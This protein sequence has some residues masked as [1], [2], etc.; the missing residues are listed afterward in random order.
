MRDKNLI[1]SVALFSELYN[2]NTY[3]NIP[4]IIAEFIRGAIIFENKYSFNSTE[5][6]DL[7][8]KIYGFDIPESVIRTTLQNKFKDEL[9]RENNYYHFNQN[10]KNSSLN[11]HSDFQEISNS[12]N[13]VI[14]D[15]YAFIEARKKKQL[16]P[17]EKR[18]VLENV[19]QFL[20]DNGYS[21]KYSDLISAYVLIKEKDTKFRELLNSIKEGL[22]LYQGI[23]YTADL[24]QL[25]SW[26]NDLTIYLGTEHLFN[27]LGYN[28]I[29]YKEIFD[30]FYKLVFE[31]NSSQKN[32]NAKRKKIELKYLEETKI[33]IDNFFQTAES[34]KKGNKALDPSKLA[35]ETILKK[36]SS[37]SD[38]KTLRVQFDIELKKLGIQFH[39]FNYSFDRTIQYN[40]VDQK[41]IDEL[42]KLSEEKGRYFSEE[43]CLYY[44]KLFTKINT[45]RNGANNNRFEKCGHLYVTETAFVKYLAHNN[46]VK[47]EDY[48]TPFAKD[49]DFVTTRFWFTL[50]KG[51]S[52]KQSLPKSFDV[53]TKAKIILSSHL[54]NGIS[55]SYE[56]LLAER[57][58]GKLTDE[59]AI[60]RSYSL[61]EKPNTPEEITIE[62]LDEALDFIQNENHLENFY[63][64]KVRKEQLLESTQK[65]NEGLQLKITEYE[66]KERELAEQKLKIQFEERKSEFVNESWIL[67]RKANN[68]DLYLFMFILLA[69]IYLITSAL[70]I[71][72][73]KELKEWFLKLEYQQVLL[74]IT[75]I[76]VLLIDT[77]GSKYLFKKEQVINGW[78]WLKTLFNFTTYKETKIDNLEKEYTEKKA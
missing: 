23:N 59:E 38:I 30:D 33:E 36:S 9:R 67:H 54:T 43:N 31:I 19:F 39:D 1:A 78:N 42:K 61:R 76:I 5:L 41:V 62:N 60:A 74:I 17:N 35:M 52:D 15:I 14:E 77:M 63:R 47:F 57:K 51:F 37:L 4:E 56:N 71:G 44:F 13:Q 45:F 65:E 48:D 20:M 2:N 32:T 49:I 55:K 58:S 34:I 10:I 75:Y 70:F 11:I 68:K 28:G 24:N 69:N 64:E 26:N 16:E 3:K 8:N 25:G 40:V 22:I 46:L 27:A 73:S 6:K 53:I 12:Q 66:N 72:L 50:K 29:L 21:E 7:L 18:E